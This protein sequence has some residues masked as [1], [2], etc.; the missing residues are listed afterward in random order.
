MRCLARF[1]LVGASGVVVDMGTL[2]L[3]TEF[4][5]LPLVL[6]KA[7][8]CELAIV[9]NFVWNDLWTF[10]GADLGTCRFW[11]LVWFNGVS[12]AG[13][14]LN[15]LLF[16]AQVAGLGLNLYLANAVA[17]AL[18]AGFNYTFSRH[19]AWG[20]RAG[21]PGPAT[22]KLVGRDSI[23]P[24]KSFGRIGSTALA[25]PEGLRP[26]RREPRPTTPG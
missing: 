11:R 25:A 3:L 15:V 19:W 6:A 22:M 23:E 7:L 12:L 26:H 9:N 2:A 5:L 18:V 10:H 16:Q 8:A 24:G 1:C 21:C 17:I 13:L 4:T 14:A 20:V